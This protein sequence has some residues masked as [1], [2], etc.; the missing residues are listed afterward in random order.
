NHDSS[1]DCNLRWLKTNGTE[2]HPTR[3][4]RLRG[5]S[6]SQKDQKGDPTQV[7]GNRQPPDPA[8]I[9]QTGYKKND[10]PYQNPMNLPL[11]TG[12]E[13]RAVSHPRSTIDG[14]NSKD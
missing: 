6:E 13:I 1:N 2:V 14:K 9:G 4:T 5:P 7:R 10:K 12:G 11:V 3:C 8:I